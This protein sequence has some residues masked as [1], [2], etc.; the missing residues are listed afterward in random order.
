MD[1]VTAEV[2]E[3]RPG[4]A[5]VRAIPGGACASCS[6]RDGCG[7]LRLL[8]DGTPA[9]LEVDDPVGARVG[10]TVALDLAPR[11]VLAIAGLLY[12]FPVALAVLGAVVGR[13]LGPAWLGTSPDAG[14]VL[15][16]V[17]ALGAAFAVLA[18]LH[19][20]LAARR[21]LRV[22]VTEVVAPAATPHAPDP[23]GA[24]AAGAPRGDQ[25]G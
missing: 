3:A 21:S 17:A 16:L 12:L 25:L 20:G 23:T 4:I 22:R 2:V 19:R 11:G 13:R 14:S 5:V 15:F 10:D 9:P 18:A 8:G 6:S 1:C 7:E 24:R